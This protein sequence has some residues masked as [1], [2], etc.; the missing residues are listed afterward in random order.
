MLL[1]K[2]LQ[3]KDIEEP[4]PE[5][6]H[7]SEM[8]SADDDLNHSDRAHEQEFISRVFSQPQSPRVHWGS[9][10]K[11]TQVKGSSE[12]PSVEEATSGMS[13]CSLS[14]NPAPPPLMDSDPVTS[15]PSKE[16][17][18]HPSTGDLT[19][20][21]ITRVGV[22][23]RGAAG[24]QDLLQKHSDEK[25]KVL[26]HNFLMSLRATLKD[27]CTESTRDLLYGANH[28]P[29]SPPFTDAGGEKEEELDED[30][31]E[32]E[33]A[34]GM[35][36]AGT[37]NA[38]SSGPDFETLRKNTQELELRVR[39]FY[40]GSWILPG[41]KVGA[42][43]KTGFGL[44]KLLDLDGKVM[45]VCLLLLMFFLFFLTASL[46]CD[47]LCHSCCFLHQVTA[48]DQTAEDPALPLLDSRAQH[49]IQKRI[50]VEKLTSWCVSPH[51]SA[52]LS[53]PVYVL[54][55]L[56]AVSAFAEIRLTPCEHHRLNV[57]VVL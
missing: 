5:Q 54:L 35:D 29:A 42:G 10:P 36:A 32:D 23:K 25:P 2:P 26:Q 31:L 28:Q 56:L 41:E 40:K 1:E 6:P 53:P 50:T 51:S 34:E 7:S 43:L 19:S 4:Q 46:S 48:Q 44:T 3:E 20:L 8:F 16:N 14:E 18:G 24:L 47:L 52:L 45:L 57:C 17:K 27:W 49:V 9:P 13:V 21:K 38:P 37:R 33:D 39:E 11:H 15:L 12:E 55:P 30:D 22:S